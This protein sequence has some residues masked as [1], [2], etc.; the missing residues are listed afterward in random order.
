M[1]GERKGRRKKKGRERTRR[2][3]DEL[4]IAKPIV[5]ARAAEPAVNLILI[6]FNSGSL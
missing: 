4:S 2:R 6:E 1:M 5:H 3:R